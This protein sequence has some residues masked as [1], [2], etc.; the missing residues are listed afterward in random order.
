MPGAGKQGWAAKS[1]S[2]QANILSGRG[3]LNGAMALY[4]EQER[5]CQELGEQE[6]AAKLTWQPGGDPQESRRPGWRHGATKEQERICR[7]LGNKAGLHAAL[8]NK[9]NILK[10]RGDLD[11]AM[12]LHREAERI[13]REL[14]DKAGL[15]VALGNQ[16]LILQDLG[17][18][19]AAMALHKEQEAICREL[20]D[21]VGLSRAL[22]DQSFILIDRED[23]DGAVKLLKER[24]LL[25]RELGN[26]SELDECMVMQAKTFKKQRLNQESTDWNQLES[27]L[28][29]IDEVINVGA[30]RKECFRLVEEG[31]VIASRL[32]NETVVS[33]FE[34]RRNMLTSLGLLTPLSELLEPRSESDEPPTET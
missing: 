1:L 33:M 23:L 27:Y 28:K 30:C 3:D 12:A 15:S 32:G 20:E 4:K 24:E 18:L 13:C 5:I 31:L 29:Q 10:A 2:G 17:D 11:G 8:G 7:E 19:D 9:A 34:N 25:C 16:A 21:K 6:W 26:Q 22:R 14:G